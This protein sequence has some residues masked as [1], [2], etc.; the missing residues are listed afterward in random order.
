[1]SRS[2]WFD[3]PTGPDD[4]SARPQGA[5]GPGGPPRT[6]TRRRRGPLGTTLVVLVGLFVLGGIAA[7][8]LTDIWWY[9]SVGFRGVFVK[10]LTVKLA[11]HAIVSVSPGRELLKIV[12]MHLFS[13]QIILFF[14]LLFI[15]LVYFGFYINELI[16]PASLSP[17]TRRLA[18]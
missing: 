12:R 16:A 9:D 1:M 17:L 15:V 4:G 11:M 8:V 2:E 13:W 10:E 18:F 6:E 3:G 5:E 14:R 7:D